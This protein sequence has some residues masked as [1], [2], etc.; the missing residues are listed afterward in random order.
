LK[1][2][3]KVVRPSSSSSRQP[4][5]PLNPLRVKKRCANM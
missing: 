5:A 4:A 3:P 2:T 1:Q